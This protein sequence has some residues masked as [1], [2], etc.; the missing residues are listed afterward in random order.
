[1]LSDSLS[2]RRFSLQIVGLFAISALLLAG[3]G[4]YGTVSYVVGEQTREIGVRLAL[5]ANRRAIL[6][7]VLRYGLRLSTIGAAFGI[8]GALLISRL[9]AGLL[10]G[11]SPIDPTTFLGVTFVLTAVALAACYVP[12]RRAM[13][14]DPLTALRYE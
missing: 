8:S 3:L 11:V 13:D 4:I 7:M 12:A 2:A 6:G 9:M 14:V 5:G 1:V 10:Y